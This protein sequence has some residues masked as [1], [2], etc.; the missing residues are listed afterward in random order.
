MLSSIGPTG[1][2]NG[3]RP[4]LE[5]ALVRLGGILHAHREGAGRW[6]VHARE[7][8][9]EAVRL[10]VHDEVHLPLAVQEHVLRAMARDRR[11]PHLLEKGTQQLRVR[12]GVLDELEA[13]G[14]HRVFVFA[15]SR[16]SPSRSSGHST[17]VSM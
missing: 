6:P 12:G 11:K 15:H 5:R 17:L 8:L 3:F 1:P 14:A 9:G 4:Q 10:A 16:S 7:G 2:W 13:V